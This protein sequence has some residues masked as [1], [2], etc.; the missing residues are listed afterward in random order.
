MEIADG[1]YSGRLKWIARMK[2]VNWQFP[3]TSYQRRLPEQQ[4][5]I[6]AERRRL[7]SVLTHM[8]DVFATDCR[9]RII[10]VN[11]AALDMLNRE[12]EEV[13]GPPFWRF[14]T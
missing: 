10:L 8:S 1:D 3:L 2:L 4:E 5:S 7:D 12:R 13:M 9:G 14:W 6:D 11:D